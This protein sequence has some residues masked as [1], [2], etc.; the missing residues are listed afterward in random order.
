MGGVS[1]TL[2]VQSCGLEM[3]TPT[4]ARSKDVDPGEGGEAAWPQDLAEQL[5]T[6]GSDGPQIV[7]IEIG[8]F[9]R[10]CRRPQPSWC[11][12][13]CESANECEPPRQ[14]RKL[15]DVRPLGLVEP[16]D[17][18]GQSIV[19]AVTDGSDRDRDPGLTQPLTELHSRVLRSSITLCHNRSQHF[20]VT[21]TRPNRLLQR[22]KDQLGRPARAPVAQDPPRLRISHER[23]LHPPRPGRDVGHVHH[24]QP[25]RGRG[26]EPPPEQVIGPIWPPSA[27]RVGTAGP[28]WSVEAHCLN[29]TVPA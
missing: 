19:I 17:R 23:H 18:L 12:S 6:T 9:Q 24:P 7:R 28:A 2:T 21:L 26:R 5:G 22:I 10:H 4:E 25:F 14:V 8:D 20:S 16:V 13:E 11:S 29:L 15:I 27:V 3:R 1:V